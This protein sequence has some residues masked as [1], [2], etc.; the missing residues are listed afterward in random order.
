MFVYVFI[1]GQFLY[2][3]QEEHFVSSYKA[4]PPASP[5]TA[6]SLPPSAPPAA[7][8]QTLSACWSLLP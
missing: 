2:E 7:S 3:E 8:A 5:S 1:D 4:W 6:P